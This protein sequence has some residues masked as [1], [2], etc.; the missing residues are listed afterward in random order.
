MHGGYARQIDDMASL[1]CG[2]VQHPES[3][4]PFRRPPLSCASLAL[5]A[6]TALPAGAATPAGATLAP[7]AQAHTFAQVRQGDTVHTLL[8]LKLDARAGILT[9]IDL[10]ASSGSYSSDA[11]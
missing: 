9:A 7:V 4:M 11:F 2:L 3:T 1:G 8:A 10:S 6:L 5:A